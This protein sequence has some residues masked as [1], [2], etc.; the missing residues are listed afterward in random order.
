[1]LAHEIYRGDQ[2]SR[3]GAVLTLGSLSLSISSR[4]GPMAKNIDLLHT[5][6]TRPYARS[7]S[8]SELDGNSHFPMDFLLLEG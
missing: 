8:I 1:M 7:S 3:G 4:D 6:C 5:V 2:P